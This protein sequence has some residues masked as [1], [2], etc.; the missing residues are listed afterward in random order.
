MKKIGQFLTHPTL[1]AIIGLVAVSAIIW[2]AGPLIKFGEDNAAPLASSTSRLLAI[3]LVVVLWGLNNLRIQQR[4]TKSNRALAKDLQ[5][6]QQKPQEDMSSGQAAEEVHQ[7]GQRFSD[8]LVTLNKLRFESKGRKRALYELPWYIIIG[9]PG[10]GKTTALVNSGLEFPL[11]DQFGKGAVQGVGG[12]RNCDWW[13]TNEAVLI[14]TAGRYTT[15]DSHRVVDSSAWEGFLNLLKRHRRRR[16]INGAIVAISLQDMLLQTDDERALH[17]RTIRTRLDELMNKLEIRFP[18]YLMFTKADLVPGFSEFFEDLGKEERDQ[19]WG[20]SLPNSRGASEA[21]DFNF[22]SQELRKLSDRLY[23]RVLWRMN[24]ERDAR[25]GAAIHGFP[26]QMEDV[27]TTV[28]S[29]IEQAFGQNRFDVQPYLRGIYLSSGTQDGTPIDRLMTN[30]AANF[31]FSG[32]TGGLAPRQGKSFFI[33]RLLRDVIF[34]EAELVGVNAR[35]ERF[36][37]WSLRAAYASLA[38][39]TVAVLFAWTGSLAKHK[40]YMTQVTASVAD[41]AEQERR[42]GNWNKDAE[43]VIPA[44]DA[45]GKASAIYD[46]E[47]LP[48]LKS[49]GL[50]DS[51]V[52]KAADSAYEAQLQRLYMP[53]LLQTMESVLSQGDP[54]G[55]LYHSFRVYMM[56]EHTEHMDKSMIREWFNTY[57]NSRHRGDSSTVAA[58]RTHLDALLK[59]ELPAV[60]LNKTVVDQTRRAL[61]R[62]PASQRVYSRIK[63]QEEN[64]RAVD[65]MTYFGEGVRNV[66]AMNDSAF[67]ALS[68]PFM[69]TVEGY[70]TLDLSVDSPI[71]AD[72][73]N[74]RWV[75]SDEGSPHKEYTRADL[76]TISDQVKEH[77]MADYIRTWSN[78]YA[79]LDLAPFN[80]IRDASDTLAVFSDPVYSPARAVLE[81]GTANTQLTPPVAE[82]I[83]EHTQDKGGRLGKLGTAAGLASGRIE[84]TPVDKRFREIH[85][86]TRETSRSAAPI[87]NILQ[88]IKQVEVYMRD[89]AM[90]PD[91]NKAAFT[92]A[93]ARYQTGAGNPITSLRTFATTLP[94]EPVGRWLAAMADES[95]R[96]MLRAAHQHINNEWQ[97]QV[98]EPYVRALAGRYPLNPTS[99][100]EVA[101]Y[102]FSVFF[103]P[104]GT[105]DQ[106]YREYIDPFIDTRGGWRNKVVDR[107]SPGFSSASL[108][109]IQKALEIQKALFKSNGETPA[110]ELELRPH[111]M[112]KNDARFELYLGDQRISYKHGPKFWSSLNWLGANADQRIRLTF[113]DV[114]GSQRDRMY[115]GSW[116]WFR[117]MDDAQIKNTAQSN[118]YL[119]TFAAE[120]D[121]S[122]REVVYEGRAR[123]VNSPF[124]ASIFS[125]FKC[126]ETI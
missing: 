53:R 23:D 35:Y 3:L 78:V 1:I 28:Q 54:G 98:R 92:I 82:S 55:D 50:H 109:Q 24:Q 102:D 87:E 79:V 100:N 48:W 81:V 49:L 105:M 90:S 62:L 36:I 47:S 122:S 6:G 118:V 125:G 95:W 42:V 4:N 43:A 115:T 108:A 112:D 120:K 61:L 51:R 119:I 59:L 73:L 15:Q 85:L 124:D 107:Y 101:L 96:V 60:S 12:T 106:F 40:Q 99:S 111:L 76:Q 56:F 10:S 72:I 110:I 25:R 46:Q 13:F 30:V 22:I 66:Y 117:L 18:V 114:N 103:K 121:G 86:L 116:S 58:L 19:V 64:G 97:A 123:S 63:S 74:E 91:P 11:G 44:L 88:R 16:P 57:W 71:V 20:L 94:D 34:P 93:K 68:V 39:V 38:A 89:V 27:F 7:I 14:D 75:F 2:F 65:L 113:E 69:F 126:P 33:T 80:S 104:N 9:P 70:K 41:F 31:G 32:D 8:A 45:I 67:A 77:Y 29:F 84:G 83:A 26:Q 5:Q 17:A 52:E 37:K 21:P